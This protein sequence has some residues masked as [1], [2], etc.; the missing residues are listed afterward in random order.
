MAR[1][2]TNSVF[3][4]RSNPSAMFDE[5]EA[6]FDR[7]EELTAMGLSVPAVTQVFIGLRNR[8]IDVGKNAYTI[9]QAFTAL[10][11]LLKGGGRDA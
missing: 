11:P 1:N 5:T 7:A 9:D 4:S 10:L 8:G 2:L 3:E 6:V